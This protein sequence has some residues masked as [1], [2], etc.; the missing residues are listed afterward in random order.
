MEL[1]RSRPQVSLQ[2]TRSKPKLQLTPCAEINPAALSLEE[3]VMSKVVGVQAHQC[4]AGE[5][6]KW[7][8]SLQAFCFCLSGLVPSL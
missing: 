3:T 8:L 5:A 4:A 1:P 2:K 7:S 6:F